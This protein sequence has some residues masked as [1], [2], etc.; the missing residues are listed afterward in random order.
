MLASMAVVVLLNCLV[1]SPEA[2]SWK[3]LEVIKIEK[4]EKSQHLQA[5]TACCVTAWKCLPPSLL[6]EMAGQECLLHLNR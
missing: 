4:G 5:S 2:C 6:S 1:N 3:I